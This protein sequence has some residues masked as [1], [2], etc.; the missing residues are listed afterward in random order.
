MTLP[1]LQLRSV[2]PAGCDLSRCVRL[3]PTPLADTLKGRSYE[4]AV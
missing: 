3:L 4:V 2:A 1:P